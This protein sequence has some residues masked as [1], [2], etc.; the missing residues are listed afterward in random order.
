MR[1]AV[2][3]RKKIVLFLYF[4]ASTDGY[5]ALANLF[6]V[7]SICIREVADAILKNLPHLAFLSFGDLATSIKEALD[8]FRTKYV[9]QHLNFFIRNFYTIHRQSKCRIPGRT[10][11]LCVASAQLFFPQWRARSRMLEELT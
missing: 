7:F 2:E 5:R 1:K 3:V 9:Q 10:K 6:R 4:I 8:G 11:H